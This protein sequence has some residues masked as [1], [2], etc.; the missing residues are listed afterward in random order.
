MDKT[1]KFNDDLYS[2]PLKKY[3]TRVR[4]HYRCSLVDG[5]RTAI[6]PWVIAAFAV[7]GAIIVIAIICWYCKCTQRTAR[8][9]YALSENEGLEM[10]RN[11]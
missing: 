8:G 11:K 4:W 1:D 3:M 9:S 7:V 6:I 10:E 5:K 2:T